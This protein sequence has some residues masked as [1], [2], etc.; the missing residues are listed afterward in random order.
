MGD[1]ENRV[2]YFSGTGN[3]Y[4]VAKSIAQRIDGK[5]YPITTLKEGD[6]IEAN[7]LCFV[8]PVYDFKPPKIVSKI[9]ENTASIRAS[10]VVAIATYGV[11]LSKTLMHFQ[12]SLQK[13]GTLLTHGYGVKAPHNA[14]GSSQF[15]KEEIN[16]R[17]ELAEERIIKIS[18]RI[19]IL[20]S[21]TIQKTSLFEDYTLIKNIST[22]VKLLSILIFKGASSLSFKVTDSCVKCHLCEKICP[23]DNVKWDVER[24]SPIFESRCTSCFA[25]VQWCPKM[26]IQF[27]NYSFTDLGI[28]NYHHPK[29]TAQEIERL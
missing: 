8:F 7:I 9:I 6:N 16:M 2:Y 18:E 17:L 10:K 20:S 5:L 14:M 28:M 4:Y 11:A 13:N 22:L 19:A 27:G 29:V 1:L 15:T 23:V 12:G 21:D 26:A 25:C 24:D 3:S